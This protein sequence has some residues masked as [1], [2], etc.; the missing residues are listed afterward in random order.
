M[1]STG[2]HVPP[3]PWW[4]RLRLSA[5]QPGAGTLRGLLKTSVAVAEPSGQVPMVNPRVSFPNESLVAHVAFHG[6]DCHSTREFVPVE[7]PELR[8]RTSQQAGQGRSRFL[9]PGLVVLRRIY[10][11]KTNLQ[12]A[13]SWNLGHETVTVLYA[14]NLAGQ[15]S[16]GKPLPLEA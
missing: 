8:P 11:C 10:V 4:N 12:S 15:W 14:Q 1:D 16:L 5:P 13:E 7:E 3:D 6:H 2:S 9:A